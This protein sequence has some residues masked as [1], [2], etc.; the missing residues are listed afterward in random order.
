MEAAGDMVG[1]SD[2]CEIAVVVAAC[3][4]SAADGVVSSDFPSVQGSFLILR[5]SLCWRSWQLFSVVSLKS[6]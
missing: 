6:R 3:I 4:D 2:C 1:D 5:M